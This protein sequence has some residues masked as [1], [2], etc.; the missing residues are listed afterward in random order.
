MASEA[1][2]MLKENIELAMA[3]G[4]CVDVSRH[5]NKLVDV[6]MDELRAELDARV[7]KAIGDAIARPDTSKPRP[8]PEVY[9]S[10]PLGCPKCGHTEIYV[11]E[12]PGSSW[13]MEHCTRCKKYWIAKKDAGFS[14]SPKPPAGEPEPVA[15]PKFCDCKGCGKRTT[16]V[17]ADGKPEHYCGTCFAA[18][19]RWTHCPK[20]GGTDVKKDDRYWDMGDVW[21]CQTCFNGKAAPEPPRGLASSREP[22]PTAG[23][24]GDKLR[25]DLANAIK[26]VREIILDDEK[27]W[28]S[29]RA[30]MGPHGFNAWLDR[31]FE[32]LM[33]YRERSPS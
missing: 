31:T 33:Q 19:W 4:R 29:L 16:I 8:L 18:P 14:V 30:A 6:A 32:L 24:A 21:R 17:Y 22:E 12:K 5:I 1:R 3:H 15:E 26:A 25:E 11:E 10:R 20:C 28:E 9:E 2:E 27:T 23:A 13:L 7:A